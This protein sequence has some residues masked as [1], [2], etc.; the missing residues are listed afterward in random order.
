MW[1]K[2]ML[3]YLTVFDLVGKAVYSDEEDIGF[4]VMEV[5][6]KNGEW[7][8]SSTNARYYLKTLYDQKFKIDN[9]LLSLRVDLR[10]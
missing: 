7:M 6:L 3:E 9:E 8:V 10:K 5:V 4:L 2:K 1:E